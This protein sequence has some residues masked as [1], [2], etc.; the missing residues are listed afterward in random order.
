M[1]DFSI[2]CFPW[3]SILKCH[4][5]I[6][7]FG[8]VL[9]VQDRPL[10]FMDQHLQPN[11]E[12]L[13]QPESTSFGFSNGWIAKTWMKTFFLSPLSHSCPSTQGRDLQGVCPP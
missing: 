6:L 8:F 3:V 5:H 12:M 4:T 13:A 1:F 11:S 9:L 10:R 7:W 2:S